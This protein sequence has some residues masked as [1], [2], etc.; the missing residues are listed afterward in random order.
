MCSDSKE[1]FQYPLPLPTQCHTAPPPPALKQIKNQLAC[2]STAARLQQT[3]VNKL[4]S[5]T[6][7][8]PFIQ[9]NRFGPREWRSLRMIRTMDSLL[10]NEYNPSLLSNPTRVTNIPRKNSPHGRLREEIPVTNPHSQSYPGCRHL[11]QTL[12][13]S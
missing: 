13:S 7:I 5:A 12:H 2:L 9:G 1:S 3:Q 11:S 8:V 4:A 10:L 6:L